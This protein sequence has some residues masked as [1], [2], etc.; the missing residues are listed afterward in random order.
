MNKNKK[1]NRNWANRTENKKP[2]TNF[3]V[4]KNMA[5]KNKLT[6]HTTKNGE[7]HKSEK[8]IIKSFK[9]MQK[10][11]IK[12]HGKITK[13]SVLNT[14]P[15]FKIVKLTDKKRRKKSIREIPALVSNYESQVSLGLKYII[16][17][18]STHTQA[19]LPAFFEK[20]KSELLA[21]AYSKN[22]AITTKNN[23]QTEALNKK[24]YFRFYRW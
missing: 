23:F 11:Q 8:A 10:S 4:Y 2:I 20:L 22:S 18:T 1:M 13:L 15:T 7:K 14:I 21:G 17:S 6:N 16:K 24:K 9:A 3:N 19:K 12:N 5:L